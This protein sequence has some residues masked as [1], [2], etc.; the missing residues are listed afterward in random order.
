MREFGADADWT[1]SDTVTV[2]PKPYEPHNYVIESDWSASSYWYEMLALC[3][4]TDA[5]IR[6]NGL[7]DGSKQGDSIVRYIFSMLGIKTS[8]ASKEPGTPTTVTLRKQ[9]RALPRLD[10]DFVSA[11]D[12]TQSVVICCA[13]MGIPF[14]FTGLASL[15][16]KET[17]RIVALEN[18]LRKLGYVINDE[19][20][21][22]LVWDG[23]RC[24]P[25]AEPLDTYDDHRMAMSLAPVAIKMPGTVISDPSVV[26]KSY[27]RY[28]DDLRRAGYD[29]K[30][31]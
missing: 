10:Y 31:L 2:N 13:M 3:G 30:Q 25:T 21:D 22:T 9:R 24:Q 16:I 1:E 5:T 11:P 4:D 26:S 17:D 7:M 28:W 29:I 19:N 27:P 14:R 23:E 15:R 18:E 12:L 20:G 8:F 6:L